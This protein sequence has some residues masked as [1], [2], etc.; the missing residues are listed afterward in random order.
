MFFSR[1]EAWVDEKLLIKNAQGAFNCKP[2]VAASRRTHPRCALTAN[3]P[4]S[5]QEDKWQHQDS[6]STLPGF[7]I[8][9]GSSASLI[10]RMTASSLALRE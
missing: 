5:Q 10:A 6:G 3:K 2:T 8:W 4:T 7:R 9:R 1:G